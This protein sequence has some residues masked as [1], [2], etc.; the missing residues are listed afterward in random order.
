MNVNIIV[1]VVRKTKVMVCILQI[2]S[3]NMTEY[4]VDPLKQGLYLSLEGYIRN[5][6]LILTGVVDDIEV[7]GR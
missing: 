7:N 5:S 3:V 6:Y 2:L 1:N 4:L